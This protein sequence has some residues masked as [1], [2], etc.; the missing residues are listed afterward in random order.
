METLDAEF[1]PLSHCVS[2]MERS[3]FEITEKNEQKTSSLHRI[4]PQVFEN[5]HLFQL[6]ISSRRNQ[7]KISRYRKKYPTQ[8]YIFHRDN[9]FLNQTENQRRTKS[10]QFISPELLRKLIFCNSKLHCNETQISLRN[11]QFNALTR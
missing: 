11:A 8:L 9:S 10:L 3:N 1:N 5:I 2:S 4:S 7:T 6:T